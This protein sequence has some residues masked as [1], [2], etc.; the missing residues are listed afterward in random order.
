MGSGQR[1]IGPGG[2]CRS[3][4]A[5]ATETQIE[6]RR[7]PCHLGSNQKTLGLKKGGSRTNGQGAA[8]GCQQGRPQAGYEE[9][10]GEGIPK[11]DC[12]PDTA[13]IGSVRAGRH[14]ATVERRRYSR[15][16]PPSRDSRARVYFSPW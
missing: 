10:R 11:E 8:P 2:E 1:K 14:A 7:P 5:C 6:P 4:A 16:L 9:N 13:H 12:R 15:E 3:G